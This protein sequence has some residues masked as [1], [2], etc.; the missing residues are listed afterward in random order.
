MLLPRLQPRRVLTLAA[1][2][3]G[4]LAGAALTDALAKDKEQDKGNGKGPPAA[5]ASQR[6]GG[7]DHKSPRGDAPG[8]ASAR[9]HGTAARGN[10]YWQKDWDAG[11]FL[12][13]GFTAAVLHELVG[14][15][16]GLLATG[17]RPLPPGIAKNLARGKPLPPGLA[18]QQVSTDLAAVLP[19]VAGH[20]WQQVGTN[21]IL[22]QAGTAL[23]AEII[24]DVLR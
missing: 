9:Q 14:T 1:L 19:R 11:D 13:A 18:R 24:R 8:A 12:A 10:E 16:D 23:V 4:L 21:L 20:E 7:K 2:L 15:R 22:I 5:Q 6:H 3:A 17:A